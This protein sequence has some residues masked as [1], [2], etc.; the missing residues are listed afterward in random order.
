[1]WP[2]NW[3]YTLNII[4]IRRYNENPNYANPIWTNCDK[5][6]FQQTRRPLVRGH[7]W[8][9]QGVGT[10]GYWTIY[11]RRAVKP[12]LD[13]LNFGDRRWPV[14]GKSL[15][16]IISVIYVGSG[17]PHAGTFIYCPMIY[18]LAQRADTG[19][20]KI[21]WFLKCTSRICD[22]MISLSSRVGGVQNPYPHFL[23]EAG[24][25]DLNISDRSQ[26]IDWR[27]KLMNS[28][29]AYVSFLKLFL[30]YSFLTVIMEM[31][32]HTQNWEIRLLIGSIF[33]IH[34][35]GVQPIIIG[36]IPH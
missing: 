23:M 35:I 9:V 28:W 5:C 24:K 4:N 10:V 31:S 12:L 27:R 19:I 16:Y 13:Y 18:H 33:H 1:M 21:L 25:H 30:V 8:R 32:T 36:Y 20:V 29:K 22:Q 6:E 11:L 14:I 17:E 15:P 7:S 3:N 26:I 2:W 34:N